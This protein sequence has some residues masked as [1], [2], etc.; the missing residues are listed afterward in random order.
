VGRKNQL[1]L[2][3]LVELATLTTKVGNPRAE[4]ERTSSPVDVSNNIY[5]AFNYMDKR[6]HYIAAH[7][8]GQEN[9]PITLGLCSESSR[10]DLIN[11]W[12]P[13]LV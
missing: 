1:D 2:N 5:D 11:A 7:E 4:P 8:S 13:H 6:N 10:R 9:T 12:Y 3:A